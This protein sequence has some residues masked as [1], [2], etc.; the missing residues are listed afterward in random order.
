MTALE[1]IPV[2]AGTVI[3][4]NDNSAALTV[5]PGHPVWKDRT[6]LFLVPE[7]FRSAA[8]LVVRALGQSDEPQIAHKETE[9]E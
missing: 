9:N 3:R 1:L 7:D 8:A 5:Q 6:R 4:S 2:A